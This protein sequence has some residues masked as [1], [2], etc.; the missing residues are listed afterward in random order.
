MTH[1]TLSRAHPSRRALLAASAA[2]LLVSPAIVR[3]APARQWRCVTSWARNM[4][5]PGV[6][7]RRLA[8][9]ITTLSQGEL[10]IAV[11]A[12]GEIVPALQVFDAVSAGTVEMGHT[13][14]VF[15]GGKMPVAPL[16]TTAPFGLTP[17][18]HLGWLD[19]GGQALWD[20]LYA[21]FKVKAC[22]GG[23]TG[24]SSAG[25][26]K[27]EIKSLADMKGLRIRATG[28]GG[29]V[30]GALGATATAI[31]PGDTY[32]ALERGVIDAVELLAPA[33]D[34]PL[35]LNQ[36]APY[37]VF[38][39][40][41][42]PNGASE[43]LIGDAH[44]RALP[45]HLQAIVETAARVEHDMALA[46]SQIA[47]ARAVTQLAQSG[48]QFG[49]LPAD[50]LQAARSASLQ[51]L[52]RIAATSPLARRIVDSQRAH[53]AAIHTWRRIVASSESLLG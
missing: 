25:W 50:V 14:A 37:C 18:A 36:I 23:N 8:E 40:F 34:Q 35:G 15:W 48:T 22:V 3:A 10:T 4:T 13:A 1:S 47:N 49:W 28:I 39:G 51:T 32:A 38:P 30:F 2:S 41:N 44:W 16:F 53:Q 11:F 31:A 5:G 42:K 17:A 12:A 43:L 29:E 20:D 19:A 45:P 46:E 21:P 7:A 24:P 33:N 27:R 6:S 9:R 52:D 26:Y